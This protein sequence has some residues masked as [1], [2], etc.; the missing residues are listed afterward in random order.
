MWLHYSQHT[1]ALHDGRR[2][3]VM[4]LGLPHIISLE[5]V[6]RRALMVPQ[7]VPQ[8]VDD[9][10]CVTAVNCRANASAVFI[11]AAT[12]RS[13]LP[14]SY[15]ADSATAEECRIATAA[16]FKTSLPC[17]PSFIQVMKLERQSY[18]RNSGTELALLPPQRET[19][20]V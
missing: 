2:W 3:G 9:D 7:M 11:A 15:A 1:L 16:D 18:R 20:C 4:T 19:L 17:S 6:C 10:G 5:S 8:M 12:T 13:D 14:L